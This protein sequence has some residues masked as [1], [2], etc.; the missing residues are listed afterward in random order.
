VKKR[1]LM[2]QV[3][4][5]AKANGIRPSSLLDVDDTYVAYCLDEAVTTW[6]TFIET[7]LSKIEEKTKE[8]TEAKMQ[9]R[10]RQVLG[11]PDEVKGSFRDPAALFK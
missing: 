11:Q 8:A 4:S 10:L 2:W 9:R 6:G 7:E 3:W 5:I 1:D